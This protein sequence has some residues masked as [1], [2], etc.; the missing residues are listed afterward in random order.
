MSVLV[1][2]FR[3]VLVADVG[4]SSKSD[5][6]YRHPSLDVGFWAAHFILQLSL[7]FFQLAF[8][9]FHFGIAHVGFP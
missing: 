1:A 7:Q 3:S 9:G 2:V 8:Q 5:P 6:E 4:F